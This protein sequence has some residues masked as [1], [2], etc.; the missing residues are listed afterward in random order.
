[1]HDGFGGHTPGL[2]GQVLQPITANARVTHARRHLR[3]LFFV[4]IHGSGIRFASG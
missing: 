1:M 4:G 3:A 2:A